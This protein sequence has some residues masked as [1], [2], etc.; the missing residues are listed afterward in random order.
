[1]TTTDI[2]LAEL[3]TELEAV[4]GGIHAW[5]VGAGPLPAN[6]TVAEFIGK[7]LS[8]ANLAQVDKNLRIQKKI[9]TYGTPSL[10]TPRL[11]DD[12]TYWCTKT[13]QIQTQVPLNSALEAAVNNSNTF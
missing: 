4:D 13:Y 11:T 9:A 8:A 12:N 1:M 3:T 7:V 5:L 2:T 6:R 10:S